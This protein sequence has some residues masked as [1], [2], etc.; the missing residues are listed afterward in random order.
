VTEPEEEPKR[1][2]VTFFSDAF[3]VVI[4]PTKPQAVK[5]SARSTRR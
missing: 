4:R 2:A 5:I 1:V 3:T